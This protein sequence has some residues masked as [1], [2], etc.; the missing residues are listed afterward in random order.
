MF[1]C[2]VVCQIR[3]KLVSLRHFYQENRQEGVVVKDNGIYLSLYPNNQALFLSSPFFPPMS[4]IEGQNSVK[5]FFLCKVVQ[6]FHKLDPSIANLYLPDNWLESIAVEVQ[7][8][9]KKVKKKVSFS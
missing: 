1:L 3:E 5:G 8:E 4:T 7:V 9:D 6:L 2:F